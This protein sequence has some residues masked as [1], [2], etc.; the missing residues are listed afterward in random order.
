MKLEDAVS[1]ILDYIRDMD[2]RWTDRFEQLA[3]Q[4]VVQQTF[5]TEEF[6]EKVN[7][8]PF[9]VREWCRLGR[10]NAK[11]RPV[12]GR[13]N[14]PEWEISHAE[15]ERYLNHRLLPIDPVRNLRQ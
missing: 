15:L 7:K 12:K 9:T 3:G 2:R 14:V 10:I 13:G 4:P 8:S 1:P 11:K 6:A 5:S